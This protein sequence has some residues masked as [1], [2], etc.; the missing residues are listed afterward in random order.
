[1]KLDSKHEAAS[2]YVDA[3]NCYKKSNP[4][5]AVKMLNSAIH[6]FEDIGRLSMAAKYYKEIA[7]IYEKEED[8]EKAMLYYD[9]AADLYSG[10]GVES[11]GN[12]CKLKVAQYAASLEQYDRAIDIY[13]NVARQSMNNNLLKYSVKGY[14]LNA[15][16]CQICGKDIVAVHNAIENYQELDPT[17]NST[18]E[19]KFLQDLAT[20]I[21]EV[22]T[23]K[24][25]DVVK[26]FD[27]MS[28]L[29]QWKT[30][31]LL[32]AKK[33][34]QSKEVVDDDDLT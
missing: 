8:M 33:A 34:L 20:A 12:Q 26:E 29:D 2:A 18:R 9:K 6:M 16:L 5:E 4:T 22:D 7:D 21:D 1:L 10:E 11:T 32:R 15:G 17:F 14:L 19:C 13:E 24:F 27:S 28:R 31:L 25:T 23:V 3:A 30:T